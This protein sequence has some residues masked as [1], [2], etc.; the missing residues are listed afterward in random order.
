VG[1]GALGRVPVRL[2][3]WGKSK[4]RIRPFQNTE[5]T[6]SFETEIGGEIPIFLGT[7]PAL[8]GAV[9]YIFG[10]IGMVLVGGHSDR[11][12]ARRY[13]CALSCL[14]AAIGLVL[15][16]VFANSTVLAFA[17]LILGTTGA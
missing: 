17:A 3:G 16:G 4:C 2:A 9:P 13:H 1:V 6:N 8:A 11:S 14:A 15:I 12:L 10:V 5:I 7:E